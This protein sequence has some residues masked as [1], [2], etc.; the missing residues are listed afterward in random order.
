MV[1]T[2][3]DT[4]K[5]GFM[6]RMRNRDEAR[7]I[8][9]LAEAN[10]FD[11]LWLGDHLVFAVPI[12]DPMLQLAQAAA[13]SDKLT[14]AT[15]VYLLP[16]RHPTATAKMA[17][18]LDHIS[19]GNF[20]FGTG[21]GGEFPGEFAAAGVPHNQR[22]ARTSEAI[23]VIRKLWSGEEIS[24]DGKHFQLPP[25]RMLPKP[26][27]PGGPPI[28]VG[29]RSPAALRR[30]ATLSDGWISYVVTPEMFAESLATIDANMRDAGR[31]VEGFGTGHLLF[32]RIDD[33]FDTAWDKATDH[34]STRYAMDFRKPAK[35][36][37]AL[38]TPAQVAE[39]VRAF[40]AAGVRHLVLDPTGPLDESN[41]QLARF[42][43]DVRPLIAD[44]L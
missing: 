17:A 10:D 29:G 9:D 41:A 4:L 6:A 2:L 7:T 35:R 5:L 14:V 26:V 8:V 20:I 12:L 37:A 34:L 22:G 11:S 23:E 39:S 44:L 33:D 16:L 18:T 27:Q 40:H 38:G 19:G 21:V 43:R 13:L 24:H 36:Y 42:A 3:D 28:W 31:D 32:F 30:A 25:T 1:M 15:G